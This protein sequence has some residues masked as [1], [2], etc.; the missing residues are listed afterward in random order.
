MTTTTHDSPTKSKLLPI[1]LT[2]AQG[3]LAVA[4][5]AS[6]LMKLTQPVAEMAHNPQMAR[7]AAIPVALLRFIGAAELAGAIGLVAPAVTKIRPRLV[8]LAAAG[9]AL[10]MVLAAL[11]HVSRGEA[12]A[13]PVNVALG[14]LAAFVAW[15]RFRA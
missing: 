3:L 10:V 9:L 5:A 8:P 12:G 1:V 2:S 7:T 13:L 14:A 4:F 15:G 11:F 6:G